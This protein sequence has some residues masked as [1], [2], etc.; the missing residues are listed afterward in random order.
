[1]FTATQCGL[2]LIR[3]RFVF[4]AIPLLLPLALILLAGYA[5]AAVINELSAFET[6]TEFTV[7]STNDTAVCGETTCTLRGAIVAANSQAGADTVVFSLPADSAI[8]LSA[9]LP[10][11]TDSLA[12]DGSVVP[13]LTINGAT[14]YRIFEIGGNAAV[15]LNHLSLSQGG[16]NMLG[17]AILVDEDG[18]LTISNC[19]FVLNAAANRGGA[20]HNDG[21]KVIVSESEF[22]ENSAANRGGAIYNDGGQLTVGTSTFSTNTTT[23]SGEGGGA[24]YNSGGLILTASNFD[25]NA[26]NSTTGGGGAL[27]NAPSSLATVANSTFSTN[28]AVDGGGAIRNAGTL[29]MTGSTVAHNLASDTSSAGGG[30]LNSSSGVA[31]IANSTFHGNGAFMGGGIRNSALLTLINVTLSENSA[32]P[33]Y[34]GG[35]F[36]TGKGTLNYTNSILANS[37]SGSDCRN[38]GTIAIRVE[39]LVESGVCGQ[40]IMADPVLGP[41]QDN[42]GPTWTQ[43]LLAGSPAVNVGDNGA[44]AAD[45]VSNVD[46]RGMDRPQAIACDLGAYEV[47]A[48][49]G[50]AADSDSPTNLGSSTTFTA[51]VTAGES[52]AYEW[53]FGDGSTGTGAVVSHT[54]LSAGNYTAVVT[55]TNAASQLTATTEVVVGDAISGLTAANDSPTPLGELTHLTATITSGAGVSYLWDFGDGHDGGGASPSHTYAAVGSYTA[56]VTATNALGSAT[57]ST[58]VLVEESIAGLTAGNDGPTA[59][60]DLTQLSATVTAGSN[61]VYEWDFG[62]GQDGGGASPSHTYAAVGSYTAVVTATNALGSATASTDVLVEEVIAGLAVEHDTL[63]V[64]GE[65]VIFTAMVTAGSNVVY[66]WDFGDGHTSSGATTNHTYLESGQFTIVVTATNTISQQMLTTKITVAKVLYRSYMPVIAKP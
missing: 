25:H 55:A 19:R 53:T 38:E 49:A 35:L 2:Q 47:E 15:S 51:T 59:L 18:Q 48:I 56:V 26:V 5:H 45:P 46:Q 36:N 9:A 33:G 14:A 66:E 39:N 30:L 6:T 43:A 58:D 57:A 1:M 44:C 29:T 63:T 52:V 65:P 28:S 62:D 21:G 31:L 61:V 40:D 7:N 60:G 22:S 24:I 37:L 11:I 4:L 42:G 20:I 34:G 13:G 41:L 16:S 8:S 12:I 3:K 64:L 27:F 10:V 23:T 50:L 54:Y 32:D 17:G